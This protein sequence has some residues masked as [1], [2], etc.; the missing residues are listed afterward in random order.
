MLDRSQLNKLSAAFADRFF[1]VYPEWELFATKLD[2]GMF[3]VFVPQAGTDRQ[4]WVSTQD[5]ELTIGFDHWHEHLGAF[6]GLSDADAIEQTMEGVRSIVQEDLVVLI[7]FR[8][9]KWVKSTKR[10]PFEPLVIEPGGTTHVYS[11]RGTHDRIL[12]GIPPLIT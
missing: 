9:G 10:K 2:E 7:S 8:G 11:W 4:L 1:S 3:E 6:L 5:N 12:D